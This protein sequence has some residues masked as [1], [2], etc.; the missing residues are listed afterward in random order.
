V[1]YKTKLASGNEAD[2]NQSAMR[3]VE[4]KAATKQD[5]THRRA[6]KSELVSLSKGQEFLK[7]KT[8]ENRR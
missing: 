4:I 5:K 2:P 6:A 7:G 8:A 1:S 3:E